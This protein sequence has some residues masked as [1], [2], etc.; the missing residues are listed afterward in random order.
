MMSMNKLIMKL[1]LNMEHD[2]MQTTTSIAN[3]VY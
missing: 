2:F 1:L 3:L